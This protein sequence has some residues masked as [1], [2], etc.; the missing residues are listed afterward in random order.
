MSSSTSIM[1]SY[2]ALVAASFGAVNVT[3][4]FLGLLTVGASRF[5]SLFDRLVSTMLSDV[6]VQAVLTS[7][8]LMLAE[9]AQ[10][11]LTVQK[12]VLVECGC[13]FG[14][15]DSVEKSVK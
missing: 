15:K 4:R 6:V 1:V 3:S 10:A 14:L 9:C 5:D 8:G 2:K 13:L 7:Q 12:K 11:V